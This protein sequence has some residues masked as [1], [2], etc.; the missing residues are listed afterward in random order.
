MIYKTTTGKVLQGSTPIDILKAYQATSKFDS[1]E[2]F[3]EYLDIL[4]QRLDE[5]EGKGEGKPLGQKLHHAL[6][7]RLI[8]NGFLIE[9]E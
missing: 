8:I 5:W 7:M 2:S 6:V 4:W 3:E 1:E 9:V